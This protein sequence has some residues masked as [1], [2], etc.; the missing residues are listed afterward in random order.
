MSIGRVQGPALALVVNKEKEITNFKS[1]SYWQVFLILKDIELK[2]DKNF[3]DKAEVQQFLELVGKRINV[4]TTKISF[5]LY[6][7]I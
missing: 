7:W 5:V 4:K 2:C 6:L 3:F 1:E